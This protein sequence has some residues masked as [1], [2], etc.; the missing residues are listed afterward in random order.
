MGRSSPD[1]RVIAFETQATN[2]LY[3]RNTEAYGCL[4]SWE[5]LCGTRNNPQTRPVSG[6]GNGCRRPDGTVI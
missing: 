4:R 1:S 3:G 6:F 2:Q 5:L